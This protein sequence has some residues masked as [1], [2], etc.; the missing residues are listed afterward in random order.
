MKSCVQNS[1]ARQQLLDAIPGFVFVKDKRSRYVALSQGVSTLMGYQNPEDFLTYGGTDFDVRAPACEIADIYISEDTQVVKTKEPSKLLYKAEYHQ[2]TV[3][4]LCTKN[5]ITLADN[6]IG[7]IG[8]SVDV[9]ALVSANL[10][11]AALLMDKGPDRISKNGQVCRYIKPTYDS[12]SFTVRQSECLY[13]LLRGKSFSEIGLLLAI[14]KRTVEDHVERI[15]D[16]LIC[17][18]RSQLIEAAVEKGYFN[19]I[20]ESIVNK[21][22]L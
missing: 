12:H 14:S 3:F 16:K 10:I 19:I 7:V 17:D 13:Y 22:R 4:G 2:K 18:S 8:H 1:E 9:S 15:K 21:D 20:P 6:G 11:S 5:L